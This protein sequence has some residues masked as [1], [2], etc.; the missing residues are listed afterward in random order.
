[1]LTA[2]EVLAGSQ[3]TYVVAIPPDGR[4]AYALASPLSPVERTQ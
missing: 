4:N 2:E 3:V 1:M